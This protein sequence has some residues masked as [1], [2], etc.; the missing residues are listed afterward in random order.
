MLPQLPQLLEVGVELRLLLIQL[1]AKNPANM[2][3]VTL[4]DPRL[5][6][7][8]AEVVSH[9]VRGRAAYDLP[10]CIRAASPDKAR[11]QQGR[12][13]AVATTGSIRHVAT[14]FDDVIVAEHEIIN[15]T[16]PLQLRPCCQT[17]SSSSHRILLFLNVPPTLRWA[18]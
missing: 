3:T 10:N 8:L 6:L 16:D 17:K 9:E 7:S 5:G 11:T 14:Q 18:E 2:C 15:A 1:G 12:K 13:W 4:D